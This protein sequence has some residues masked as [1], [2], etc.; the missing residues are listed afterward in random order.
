MRSVIAPV[1]QSFC[2]SHTHTDRHTLTHTEWNFLAGLR[3]ALACRDAAGYYAEYSVKMQTLH[4]VYAVYYRDYTGIKRHTHA[5][6]HTERITLKMHVMSVNCTN[7]P[8]Q[9]IFPRRNHSA[10]TGAGGGN[11]LG[12]RSINLQKYAIT[13]KLCVCMCVCPVLPCPAV[14]L[15]ISFASTSY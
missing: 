5:H 10:G 6:V 9:N 8:L 13:K 2:F 15:L 3:E 12:L 11:T 14:F 1:H 7:S 4:N